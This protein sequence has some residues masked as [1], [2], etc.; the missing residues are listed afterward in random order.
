MQKDLKWHSSALSRRLD[1][2]IVKFEKK[3]NICFQVENGMEIGS[4]YHKWVPDWTKLVLLYIVL[5]C[6]SVFYITTYSEE[7]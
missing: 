4:S 2:K 7:S 3:G 1:I 6:I 5:P